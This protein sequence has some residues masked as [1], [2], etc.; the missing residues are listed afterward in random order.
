MT[1][2]KER[3]RAFKQAKTN[4]IAPQ[5]IIFDNTRSKTTLYVNLKKNINIELRK[6]L[7]TMTTGRPNNKKTLQ[8]LRKTGQLIEKKTDEDSLPEY[9]INIKP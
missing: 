9:S 5:E 1:T 3:D 7:Y 4:P 8:A 6:S 2:R